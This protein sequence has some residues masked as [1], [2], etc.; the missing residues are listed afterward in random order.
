MSDGLLRD[1]VVVRQEIVH[2]GLFK[3]SRAPEACLLAKFADA[4]VET[5]DH[6]VCLGMA[7]GDE[8]MVDLGAGAGP[9]EDMIAGRLFLPGS[10]AVGELRAV[11]RQDRAD[12]NRTGGWRG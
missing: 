4:S 3:F 2:Q 8:A 7:R 5:L 11:V 6:A 9:V 12:A 1:E 10:E